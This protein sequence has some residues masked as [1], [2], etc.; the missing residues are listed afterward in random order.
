[1]SSMNMP[2]KERTLTP[3]QHYMKEMRS[4]WQHMNDEEK[5]IY[6]EKA[7][8]EKKKA[9]EKEKEAFRKKE[10][11][12]IRSYDH[13]SCIGLDNG[14]YKVECIGPAEHLVEFSDEEQALYGV[15]YKSIT[16]HDNVWKF[17]IKKK[18]KYYSKSYTTS[19]SINSKVK[20]SLTDNKSAFHKIIYKNYKNESW[21][22]DL[23]PSIYG[24]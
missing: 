10:V 15:Q 1:M 5:S 14:S 2:K 9:K 17:N 4:R 18:K 13:I 12:L 20:W 16:I 3:Y 7:E 24:H 21:E 8:L 6:V 19:N 23:K 11:Y 22:Q